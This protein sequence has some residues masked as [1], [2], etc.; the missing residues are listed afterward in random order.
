VLYSSM[1]IAPSHVMRW[2]TPAL[3]IKKDVNSDGDQICTR[4]MNHSLEPL[5]RAYCA[6]KFVTR[7]TSLFK[8]HKRATST[9]ASRMGSMTSP[10]DYTS[11]SHADL[12]QRVSE[13]EKQLRVNNDQHKLSEG[14]PNSLV[15]AIPPRKKQRKAP[16][17]FDPSRY[18]T[19]LI[20]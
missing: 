12:I 6:S 8:R 15:N 19:R 4:A 7:R 20:A 9:A 1:F 10:T 13:L 11:W 5:I 3:L 18:T 2:S 16:K 14:A 17:Q